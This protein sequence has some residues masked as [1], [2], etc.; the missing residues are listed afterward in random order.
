MKLIAFVTAG[1]LFSVG[2]A[3]AQDVADGEASFHKCS[4]C[5]NIGPE[6]GN[7]V[8]PHL[9]SLEGRKAGTVPEFGYSEAN[10]S[11]GIT[12]NE[13]V[14]KEY[15]KHPRAKLPGTKMIFAGIKSEKE[16][17][18]LWSYVSQLDER[19]YPRQK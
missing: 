17:N 15:I 2:A 11:S 14:F 12:W 10:K 3:L 6:A 5:H 16:L 4:P 7:K 9:N 13:V 18:D 8:G 1:I 19:G